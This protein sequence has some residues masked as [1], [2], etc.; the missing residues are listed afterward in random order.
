MPTNSRIKF[1]WT[2]TIIVLGL[3]GLALW[4]RTD[5]LAHFV[6]ADEH[7]WIYRS[8]TFLNAI[9]RRDWPATEVWL[10]PGVTTT[11]LG[12]LGL[13]GYYW[14][15][16]ANITPPFAD[17]L[18]SFSRTRIDLDVL[19]ALRLVMAIFTSVMSVAGYGLARHLWPRRLALLGALLLITGPYLLAVSRI[20]GHDAPA[21]CFMTASLLSL[22]L[23]R[24]Q[25]R[26]DS[27][28]LAQAGWGWLALSG[29]MAGLAVLS[30]A[31][32]MFLIPFAGLLAAADIWLH[33]RRWPGWLGGLLLWF[34]AGWLAFILGWPA[35]WV[36]PLGESWAV[37]SNAFLSSA[38]LED[39]DVP[40]F[41]SIPDL[42]AAY[43]LVNGL[44]KIS[45]IVLPG[46]I[47]ALV[48]G[49]NRLRR[50]NNALRTLLANEIFWLL[51]FAVGF[52]LFMTM[53]VK[54][55]PRY[56]LPA[57]PALAFVAAWGWLAVLRARPR[58]QPILVAGLAAANLALSLLYA[59][60]YFTYYNPLLGGSL[61]APHVVG[62]GWGEG[63]D[64][65]ARRLNA[66]P[67]AGAAT[68]GA[69]YKTSLH[70]FFDG[71]VASLADEGLDYVAFYIKQSQSGYPAPEI[72][73]YFAQQGAV[74]QVTL[75]GI[76]YAQ[77][78]R[79]PAMT[80][81]DSRPGAVLPLAYR[82]LT[83]YAP[84]G[85]TLTVDLLWP[86]A[87]D[88]AVVGPVTLA[89]APESGDTRLDS[90]APIA[91]QAPGVNVSTHRF[92][93]PPE[94]PRTTLN[95]T[96]DGQPIGQIKARRMTIPPDFTPLDFAAQRLKLRGVR[97][98]QDGHRLTVDLAWQAWPRE[99][100]DYT[101]FVQ[102]LDAAGQRV[103]GVD[104]A[105]QP[106]FSAL[107]AKEVALT[108]YELSL[109]DK[110]PPGEYRLLVGLYYF[111]GD[112]LINVGEVTLDNPVNIE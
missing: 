47:A 32:A 106:G 107:E 13:A 78:Y 33:P 76:D 25:F 20:I 1:W 65:L 95:L 37:V 53:G 14:R 85:G 17:W 26:P 63:L 35:A 39:A 90:T 21:T 108:R 64:E 72:L 51:L 59:P 5:N 4:L 7:N 105:P 84:I 41:W 16:A 80:L 8:G 3:F 79:G 83:I 28:A 97:P 9:L 66:Q 29:A 12:A 10:T 61:T 18:L 86:A 98:Q 23:A 24:R 112:E 91:A 82:P 38:G 62:I 101:V 22:L 15:H 55:S 40:I 100:I 73:D 89:I 102:L 27:G 56:I 74:E 46:V 43:Y 54:R 75:N 94:T 30:K 93:L 50:R 2:E 31:P 36:S 45:P 44:Y 77:A 70:P 11:W 111:V 68:L 69:R 6:T 87:A 34:G 92:E 49:G 88:A 48:A 99:T 110:L 104:V 71:A 103:T 96:M 57:F 19:A 109:P 67:E 60:Y 42:G 81:V 58:W 52:G